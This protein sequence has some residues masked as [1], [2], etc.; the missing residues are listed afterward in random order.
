MSEDDRVNKENRIF[1]G[2]L[3][4]SMHGLHAGTY[5]ADIKERLAELRKE[6]EKSHEEILKLVEATVDHFSGIIDQIKEIDRALEATAK[7]KKL[8]EQGKLDLA[9]PDHL[10]LFET[11]KFD[12]ADYD[13]DGGIAQFTKHEETLEEARRRLVDRANEIANSNDPDLVKDKDFQALKQEF[14]E[15]KEAHNADHLNF[16]NHIIREARLENEDNSFIAE[17]HDDAMNN[18]YKSSV[19]SRIDTDF[20]PE[21]KG[22][23][24]QEFTAAARNPLDFGEPKADQVLTSANV[25]EENNI[26]TPP[27]ANSFVQKLTLDFG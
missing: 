26:E 9:N 10:V 18:I 5:M 7:L 2:E 21:L 12:P 16:H 6:R 20:K 25:K 1:H 19:A 27:E 8:H 4:G 11:A 24:K 3:S 23:V 22:L 13:P 17:K 15:I 14:E